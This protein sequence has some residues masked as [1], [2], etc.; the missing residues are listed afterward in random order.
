[1]LGGLDSGDIA[2]DALQELHTLSGSLTPS[3]AVT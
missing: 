2:K 1:M 3:K